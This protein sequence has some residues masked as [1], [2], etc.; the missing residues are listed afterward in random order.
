[1]R[2][3]LWRCRTTSP[4]GPTADTIHRVGAEWSCHHLDQC[5]ACSDL[6]LVLTDLNA[7]V[8]CPI[9]VPSEKNDEV[10][11]SYVFYQYMYGCLCIFSAD[12]YV[13]SDKNLGLL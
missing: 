8:M 13:R 7:T 9:K 12:I 10:V 11:H 6:V 5:P 4:R 3:W 1:M 2:G